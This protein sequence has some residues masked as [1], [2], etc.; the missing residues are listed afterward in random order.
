M[1][2]QYLNLVFETKIQTHISLLSLNLL[3]EQ[4][5]ETL[6]LKTKQ[7]SDSLPYPQQVILLRGRKAD[8]TVAPALESVSGDLSTGKKAGKLY[9]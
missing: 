7:D 3:S 6:C 1:N 4:P 2:C 8:F 5:I 9:S